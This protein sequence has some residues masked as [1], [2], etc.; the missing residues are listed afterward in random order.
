NRNG[1]LQVPRSTKYSPPAAPLTVAPEASVIS[2]ASAGLMVIAPPP[3]SVHLR[4]RQ[5]GE[6][7]DYPDMTDVQASEY[8]VDT[9]F[10]R[11]AARAMTSG[12]RTTRWTQVSRG[13]PDAGDWSS[14]PSLRQLC[15]KRSRGTWISSAP[16]AL[17]SH[18][19]GG[20]GAS[21]IWSCGADGPARGESPNR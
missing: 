17:K 6:G 2:C 12:M 9:L 3:C 21:T 10:R 13:R 1:R 5:C 19:L 4:R 15:M 11:L 18:H 8:A 16:V 14:G 20:G 7:A